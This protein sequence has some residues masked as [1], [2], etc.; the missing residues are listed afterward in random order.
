MRLVSVFLY[1]K[2]SDLFNLLCPSKYSSSVW[3]HLMSRSV[4]FGSIVLTFL[5]ERH[6]LI[7]SR[8]KSISQFSSISREMIFKLGKQKIVARGAEGVGEGSGAN[9]GCGRMVTVSDTKK[10][11]NRSQRVSCDR[12]HYH[13]KVGGTSILFWDGNFWSSFFFFFFFFQFS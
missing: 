13:A 7:N 11:K 5:C 12:V 8:S 6:I 10:K 2:C 4:H 1:Y 3:M 9:G